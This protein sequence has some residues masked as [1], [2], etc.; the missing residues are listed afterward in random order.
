M[1]PSTTKEF[2][3]SSTLSNV[4]ETF[5]FMVSQPLHVLATFYKKVDFSVLMVY[6]I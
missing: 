4:D 1:I 5:N 3:V 6:N 2:K